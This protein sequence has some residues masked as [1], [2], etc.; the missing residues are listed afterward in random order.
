MT[1]E[2][3]D[4]VPARPSASANRARFSA[5]MADATPI[6]ML[7]ARLKLTSRALRHYEAVGLIASIRGWSGVR[8]YSPATVET[9]ELIVRLRSV[10]VSLADI[11]AIVCENDPSKR[12]SLTQ[13]ILE[14]LADE[15]RRG[16]KALQ[17][18]IAVTSTAS[19]IASPRGESQ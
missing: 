2:P 16:L 18:L 8:H 11:G 7:T 17:C 14:R 10:E 13:T 4:P 15:R 5:S 19:K 6:N 1:H 12:A 3:H 9:I